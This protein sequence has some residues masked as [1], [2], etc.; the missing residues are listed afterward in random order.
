MPTVETKPVLI[1]GAGP[2]GLIAALSLAKLGVPVRIV[3]KLPAFHNATRGTGTQPRSLEIYRFLGLL[4][5]YLRV[6]QPMPPFRAYKLPGGTE[7]LRTWTL[8]ETPQPTPDRPLVELSTELVDFKQDAEGVTA[9]LQKNGTERE[10]ARVAYMIGADGAKGVTRKL[11]GATFEGRT[12][13][14]DGQ[15]WADVE[16]EGLSPD[17]SNTVSSHPAGFLKY[18]GQQQFWHVWFQPGFIVLIRQIGDPGRFY[19]GIIGRHFDPVPLTEPDKF[20]E[21]IYENIQRRD[22]KFK[23][24]IAVT[25]WKPK[26]RRVNKLRSGR[27]FIVGDAAHIHS[28]TGG[29]GLNTSIQDSFN[30]AWK[31]SLVYKGLA[32]SDLLDSVDSERLPVIAQM[33]ATTTALYDRVMADKEAYTATLGWHDPSLAQLDVNY[34]W[35]PIVYDARGYEGLDDAGLK[36]RAYVGYPGQPVHAGDRAPDAPG[37]VDAS[38][39]KTQLHE[40]FKPT[41]HTFLVFSSE[42]QAGEAENIG[43]IIKTVRTLPEGTFQ[44]VLLA[45]GSGPHLQGEGIASYTDTEGHAFGTYGIDVAKVAVV[46]VRPDSYVGAFVYDEAGLRMY[47]SRVFSNA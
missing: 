23:K 8:V 45:R 28:P 37:L 2:A 39:Q 31:L 7:P 13:E 27:V 40:I 20:V 43:S 41:V 10:E 47:F 34:R 25:Y 14:G 33:L 26:M 22:L 44:I 18:F 30:I 32:S 19:V 36:A 1:V 12:V 38:G 15:V 29:Q 24:F 4:D 6:A 42:A 35:S 21:Y 9:T 46:A 3:E 16:L 5:D 11:M 17:V